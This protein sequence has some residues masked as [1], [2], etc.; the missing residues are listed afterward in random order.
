MHSLGHVGAEIPDIP[1][2]DQTQTFSEMITKIFN[3]YYVPLGSTVHI[4]TAA[5]NPDYKHQYTE[6]IEY[7]IKNVD[8]PIVCKIHTAEKTQSIDE[9]RLLNL[10][11]VDGL[12][13]FE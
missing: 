6:V 12:A 1:F 10:I 3:K 9:F 2:N 11:M 5:T 4:I 13:A 8:S 7:I